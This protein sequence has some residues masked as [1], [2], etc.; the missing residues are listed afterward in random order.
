MSPA[1]VFLVAAFTVAAAAFTYVALRIVG[2]ERAAA[3]EDAHRQLRAKVET[4]TQRLVA[5]IAREQ[6]RALTDPQAVVVRDGVVVQ[7]PP[8]QPLRALPDSEGKD[9][10][11]DALL[12]EAQRLEAQQDGGADAELIYRRLLAEKGG[13]EAIRR[14]ATWRLAALLGRRGVEIESNL[15]R[16][17]FLKSL[18]GET[19]ASVE[20]LLARIS[21]GRFSRSTEEQCGLQYD[22]L[23][24][25]GGGDDALVLGMLRDTLV[26]DE[27]LSEVDDLDP[28][29]ADRRAEVR[30]VEAVRDVLPELAQQPGGAACDDAGRGFVWT[31]AGDG[32][33]RVVA[34]DLGGFDA[35]GVSAVGFATDP[36]TGATTTLPLAADS[37]CET[38]AVGP[39]MRNAVVGAARARAEIDAAAAARVRWIVGALALLLV[40]GGGGVHFT[41]RAARRERDAA[42]A[43]TAFVAR[44][45][46]DLRTPLSVI[47]L[48][49]ETIASGRATRPDE[50]RE[51]AG[52]AARE[53]ERL[54]AL[55]GQVLDFSRASAR[56]EGGGA[57][58]RE[59]VDVGALL[60]EV[61]DATRA[62][63]RA[64][65]MELSLTVTGNDLHVAG[66][67]TGLATAL[68]NLVANALAHAAS[69]GRTEIEARADGDSV[70]VRVSDRGP[71]LPP[72]LGERIFDP[73]VRGPQ[74][75]PGGSGLGLALVRE[76]AGAH[77]GR[78]AAQDREGGGATFTLRLPRSEALA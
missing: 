18:D 61:V 72:G 70:E 73:F 29:I 38:L 4:E 28:A 39:L 12:R 52:V 47:R 51:F 36:R 7:P 34:C 62:A 78:V 76:V 14:L 57:R 10:V 44:V 22:I 65:G 40:L 24:R 66:D 75:R 43:R 35:T 69:G 6:A 58:A 25:L 48:Y 64:A 42:R 31:A 71:G 26:V 67:R 37:I 77:G 16:S 53:A 15:L 50:V 20:G 41:L 23:Q 1:A 17:E 68:A 59:A 21:M 56:H 45:S 9:R 63:A 3:E 54:T 32:T 30:R 27:V 8:P 2:A 49:A 60:A 74:A 13:N 46:H 55:V 5:R 33:Q 19:R 11:G